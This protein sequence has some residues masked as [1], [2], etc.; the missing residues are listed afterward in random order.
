MAFSVLS[1]GVLRPDSQFPTVAVVTPRAFAS[2][3]CVMGLAR[4]MAAR[5]GTL[6]F[7]MGRNL[8]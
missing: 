6:D 4:R 3:A 7:G 1:G 2:A 5:L 8:A